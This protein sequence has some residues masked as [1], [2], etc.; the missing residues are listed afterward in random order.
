LPPDVVETIPLLELL[1]L[2][3]ILP[4]AVLLVFPAYF[5]PDVPATLVNALYSVSVAAISLAVS[6][7][8]TWAETVI[9]HVAVL[10]PSSVVTVIVAEPA[11]TPVTKPAFVTVATSASDDDQVTFVFAAPSGLIVAV[12]WRVLLTPIVFDVMSKLTDSTLIAPASTVN[13]TGSDV[14]APAFATTFAVPTATP[15]T[16]FSEIEMY[17]EPSAISYVTASVQFVGLTVA[18]K[19]AVP[20]TLSVV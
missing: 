8:L 11:L 13:V 2:I 14:F 3:E 6:T 5:A 12:N 10:P 4:S 15:V 18:V 17:S 16:T 7:S 9:A 1:D 20:L 19:V